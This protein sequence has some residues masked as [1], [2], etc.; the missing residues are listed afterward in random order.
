MRWLLI[1]VILTAC[2]PSPATIA[3]T[4]EAPKP[5]LIIDTA[6]PT[7]EP[8]RNLQQT[9]SASATAQKAT[10]VQLGKTATI[11]ANIVNATGT[12]VASR[13]TVAARQAPKPVVSV[14]AVKRPTLAQP[15]WTLRPVVY[16]TVT[17]TPGAPSNCDPAY[18]TVCIPSP[19]PDLDCKDIP[20]RK[21]TV[22]PPDPHG[23]D[24]K[25]QDGI[26][27]ES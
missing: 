22:L 25:D 20:Y 16:Q 1:V 26:G 13:A 2:A 23:F 19:P 11:Q 17:F 21:F 3:P 27:C 12:V 10:R 24:G 4:R 6:T 14:P 5:T 15:T 7:I 9:L 8:T 18:P